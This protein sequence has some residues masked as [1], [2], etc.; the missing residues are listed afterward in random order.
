MISM[1]KNLSARSRRAPGDGKRICRVAVRYT[2]SEIAQV[3]AAAAREGLVTAAWL[4]NAGLALSGQLGRLPAQATREELDDLVD[5]TEKVRRAGVL[6]NQV[7]R[8]MHA[9]GQVNGAIEGIAAKVWQR[10]EKLDDAAMAVAGPA[11]KARRR[12]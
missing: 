2:Q 1:T 7:V 5:A 10:V 8:T 11:L 9:T 6:L 12:R 4:G 3:E